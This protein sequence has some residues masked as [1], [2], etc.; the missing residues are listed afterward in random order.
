MQSPESTLLSELE[1]KGFEVN[2]IR[3]EKQEK[4]K[5][6]EMCLHEAGDKFHSEKPDPDVFDP[7]ASIF[8]GFFSIVVAM[9]TFGAL[10]PIVSGQ[11]LTDPSR[12]GALTLLAPAGICFFTLRGFGLDVWP[13][14]CSL[15]LWQYFPAFNSSQKEIAEEEVIKHLSQQ[16]K[17]KKEKAL[18]VTVADEKQKL[19]AVKENL[20]EHLQTLRAQRKGN[21]DHG[22]EEEIDGFIEAIEVKINEID[23]A[24]E[25]I[26]DFLAEVR[27]LAQDIAAEILPVYRRRQKIL[28]TFEKVPDE[29]DV[30]DQH[31]ASAEAKLE[32]SRMNLDHKLEVLQSAITQAN[33]V[34][35]ELGKL[36]AEDALEKQNLDS[37]MESVGQLSLPDGMSEDASSEPSSERVRA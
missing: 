9:C 34:T 26:D 12:L 14:G 25:E 4:K 3:K 1:S 29:L 21:E 37:A 31:I 16:L 6:L 20:R 5:S 32:E 27:Q 11:V 22:L 8:A 33:H 30:A 18:G 7:F 2:S 15:Y 19:Q 17:E 13:L 24:L 10:L 36:T 23:D 35:A 28:S